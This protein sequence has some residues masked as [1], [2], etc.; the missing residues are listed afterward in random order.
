M[1]NHLTVSDAEF[2]LANFKSPM[3]KVAPQGRGGHVTWGRA[4]LHAV[5]PNSETATIQPLGHKRTEEVELKYLKKW[6]SKTEITGGLTATFAETLTKAVALA[7][8]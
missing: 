1:M 4:I 5:N 6:H 8:S 2:L 7:V 3:V